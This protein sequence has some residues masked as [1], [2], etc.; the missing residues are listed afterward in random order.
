[1]W[2]QTIGPPVA[3]LAC[4][5]IVYNGYIYVFGGANPATT[6][7]NEIHMYNLS[8]GVWS[9]YVTC[10]GTAPTARWGMSVVLYGTYLYVFGGQTGASAYLNDLHRLD[11][12]TLDWSGALSPTGTAP[13][14]RSGSGAVLY[15]NLWYVFGGSTAS[16]TYVNDLHRI[17]LSTLAWSGALSPSGTPPSTRRLHSAELYGTYIYV[18][19]GY[20]GSNLNDLHRLDLSTLTW[21]GALSPSGTPPT[22]RY[23]Q[24]AKIVGTNMYVFGGFTTVY[25]NDLHKLDLSS[26]AWSGALSPSGTIPT[27]R[28]QHISEVSGNNIYIYGGLSTST[29]FPNVEKN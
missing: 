26:L 24:S 20:R 19:A 9:N 27:A 1:M 13:T 11:L 6:G 25:T 15:G 3:R 17:D 16:T 29:T 8:T 18:F 14:A 7:Y 22:A 4:D 23:G 21:S 5:S 2:V 10:T 12:S 28:S